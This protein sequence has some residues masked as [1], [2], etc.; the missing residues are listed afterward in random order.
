MI[1]DLIKEKSVTPENDNKFLT[2]EEV[3]EKQNKRETINTIKWL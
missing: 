2:L 3:L 1:F